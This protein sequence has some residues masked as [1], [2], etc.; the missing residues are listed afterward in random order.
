M[1]KNKNKL[2]SQ[3]S[4]ERVAIFRKQFRED[5]CYWINQDPRCA[6]RVFLIIEDTLRTP[7]SGIA[8]PEALKYLPG[9]PWSRRLTQEHRIVYRVYDEKVDFLQCRYH[10]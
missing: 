5:L 9:N 1:S 6:Q 10:Y 3:L 8:K 7:F 2:K 4:E